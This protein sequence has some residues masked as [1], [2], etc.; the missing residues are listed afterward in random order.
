MRAPPG[1]LDGTFDPFAER[2][3]ELGEA[4]ARLL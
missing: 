1:G 3:L 2:G 4:L